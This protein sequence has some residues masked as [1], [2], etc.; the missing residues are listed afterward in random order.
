[1]LDLAVNGRFLARRPTGVD[2]FARELLRALDGLIRADDP[3]VGGIRA[4]IVAPQGAAAPPA[5]AA[6]GFETFGRLSGHAWEQLELPR[7]VRG[8]LLLNLCNTAPLAT[9]RQ[10]VVIHDA[11]TARVPA[12]FTRSFRG[13]YA[14]LMPALGRRADRVLTVSQFSRDELQAC[15]GIR[16]ERVRVVP[17]G[18]EHLLREPADRTVIERHGLSAGGYLLAVGSVVPHKN[19][20]TLLRAASIGGRLPLE[21]AIAGGSDPR[22]FAAAGLPLPP[23]VRWLG[24]VSD[25][26]LRALYENAAAFVFPSRYEGFGLPPLEAMACGCP[27]VASSAASLPEVCGDAALF[28]DCDDAGSLRAAIDRVLAD[29]ALR[30]RLRAAG[31]ERAAGFTW[32]RAA[33]ELLACLRD[34]PPLGRRAAGGTPLAAPVR[35]EAA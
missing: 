13:A 24:V 15:W 29:A 22:V 3:A 14:V 20:V 17:E 11:A 28:F 31:L 10:A 4:A 35:R 5:L 33:R 9:R 16:G 18:A 26:A 25:A 19:L 27:V 23:G 32:E 2:R 34:A 6:I 30:L 1:M 8:R 12:A 21:I 7:A